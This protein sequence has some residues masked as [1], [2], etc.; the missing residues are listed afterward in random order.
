MFKCSHCSHTQNALSMDNS[1]EKDRDHFKGKDAIGHIAEVQADGIMESTEIHGAET[2]GF[3]FSLFDAAKG[4]AVSLL[5]ISLVVSYFEHTLDQVLTMLIA[6]SLG[7]LFWKL[8]RAA[9]L[10][11]ARLE[12]LHRVMDQ[13]RHEIEVNRDQ[14]RQ[15]L[16][17]LYAAKGF[18]GKLL[19]DVIDVLMADGDRLLRVMLEEELG[20]RLEQN[21][22]PFIQGLGAGLG[23]L[24]AS[25]FCLT[26]YFFFNEVGLQ[27]SAGFVVALASFMYASF[28]KNN[29]TSAIV[30]NVGF[31]L[32]SY[33]AAFS[34]MQY[35]IT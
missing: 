9:W 17:A 21:E 16:R 3:W 2:P 31:V 18:E 13:E 4:T 23:V 5:F 24:I 7:W 30:W 15:E 1:E 12:R 19:D 34:F 26:F 25:V 22:H 32:L 6:F 27:I 20:F 11:Y 10:A 28:E 8:A 33:W 35:T 29:P 14:E